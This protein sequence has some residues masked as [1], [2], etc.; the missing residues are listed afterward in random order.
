MSYTLGLATAIQG[1]ETQRTHFRK[2][3]EALVSDKLLPIGHEGPCVVR[4]S[5]G[6]LV[7]TCVCVKVQNC[8]LS[9]NYNQPK[10]VNVEENKKKNKPYY[11]EFRTGRNKRGNKKW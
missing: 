8:T 10:C 11:S 6:V 1:I 9:Y 2:V 7:A 3:V 4:V 5:N